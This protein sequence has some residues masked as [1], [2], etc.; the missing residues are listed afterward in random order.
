MIFYQNKD[1]NMTYD[2]LVVCFILKNVC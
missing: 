1:I 2:K